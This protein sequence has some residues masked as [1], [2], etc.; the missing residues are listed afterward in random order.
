MHEK[1]LAKKE[2]HG[3]WLT[4]LEYGQ[5]V[6]GGDGGWE[7]VEELFRFLKSM[8]VGREQEKKQKRENARRN[9]SLVG[10]IQ[11]ETKT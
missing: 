10:C 1:Y 5:N 4:S 2:T 11:T 7:A 9:K 6:A 8:S 3:Q